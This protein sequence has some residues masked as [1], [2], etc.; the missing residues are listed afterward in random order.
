MSP[1]PLHSLEILRFVLGGLSVQYAGTSFRVWYTVAGECSDIKLLGF[2]AIPG[3]A[4]AP[5]ARL[6]CLSCLSWPRCSL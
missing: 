6:S 5:C 4:A 2:G 3:E 1:R